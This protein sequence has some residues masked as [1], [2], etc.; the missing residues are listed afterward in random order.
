MDRIL[1]NCSI[2]LL[3]VRLMDNE[4]IPTKWKDD[5]PKQLSY[6]IGAELVSQYLKGIP[7]YAELELRFSFHTGDL[8]SI[9]NAEIIEVMDAMYR[10]IEKS[11]SFSRSPEDNKWLNPYWAISVYPVP[12]HLRHRIRQACIDIGLPKMRE[13]LNTERAPNW[14][15]GRKS[16]KF[17]YH[18]SES[19]MMAEIQNGK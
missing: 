6:P 10:K 14:Y 9:L 16:I 3:G 17:N 5:L 12:S 18:V 13:W 11:L 15:H 2:E 4:L 7:Q 19:Q 8:H 1:I